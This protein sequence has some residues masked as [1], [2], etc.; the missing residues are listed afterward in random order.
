MMGGDA[1]D[2][3]EINVAEGFSNGMVKEMTL[4]L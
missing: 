3:V 2:L 4:G 1:C